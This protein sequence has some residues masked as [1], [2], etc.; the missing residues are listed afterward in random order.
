MS[1]ARS[2]RF[3]LPLKENTGIG[4]NEPGPG[5]YLG[6][7]VHKHAQ[8]NRG[9]RGYSFAMNA[10]RPATAPGFG[11]NQMLSLDYD[12]KWR[13]HSACPTMRRPDSCHTTMPSQPLTRDLSLGSA[14]LAARPPTGS[15][16]SVHAYDGNTG[17]KYGGAR[18]DIGT[19]RIQ[20]ATFGRA[21]TGRQNKNLIPGAAPRL[22][23]LESAGLF[24]R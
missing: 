1:F 9:P 5:D 13:M 20:T 6:N 16:N 18:F 11:S 4:A 10:A 7:D 15:I 3:G 24:G 21:D 17:G 14:C 19:R 23:L 8:H 12:V 22:A 2:Q